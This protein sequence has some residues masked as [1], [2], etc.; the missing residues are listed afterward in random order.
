MTTEPVRVE[1]PADGVLLLT[2]DRPEKRNA[3]DGATS[4]ALA[5][6]LDDLDADPELSVGVLTGAGGT[7]CAGMDLRAFLDGDAPE[8]PGRGF[9][10]LTQA[11]PAK[12]LIAAVEGYALAG[13]CELVLACDLVVAAQDATFGLPEVGLG[14]VAGSGG[15]LRLPH[16]IPRAI[17]TELALTGDRFGAGDAHRWG[18]VNRLVEPGTATD[19]AV[20]LAARIARNAPLALAATKRLLAAA[21]LPHD[22]A[23]ERQ[24]DELVAIKATEDAREGAQAFGERRAPRW[25][26]R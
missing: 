1:R 12:P 18:L 2:L 4:R 17:A 15:L 10:G 13:G 19:A 26:G 3:V 20:D 16:R 7:F 8:V 21:D 6:A 23:W 24:E 9:G 25:T 14:L 11:P 5:A 22:E